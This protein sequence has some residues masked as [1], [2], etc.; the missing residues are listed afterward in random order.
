MLI[1]T[2]SN[3]EKHIVIILNIQGSS[4]WLDF[5]NPEVQKFWAERFLYSNYEGS[6][7]HLFTW[8]DMNEPSVFNG[9]EITM[10]KDNIHH[11]DKEHREIHN[12]YGLYVVRCDGTLQLINYNFLVKL[13]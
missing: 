10:H 6:T 3:C 12:V 13:N 7:D 2:I 1:V 9:P 5:I 4:A 11:G 8:N